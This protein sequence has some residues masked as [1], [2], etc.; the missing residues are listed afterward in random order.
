MNYNNFINKDFRNRTQTVEKQR[1][2]AL[3]WGLMAAGFAVIGVVIASTT[4]NENNNE[5]IAVTETEISQNLNIANTISTEHAPDVQIQ[6]PVHQQYRTLNQKKTP[7]SQD[8]ANNE[9][10]QHISKD[11]SVVETSPDII[12]TD[13]VSA[14]PSITQTD[15]PE[16]QPLKVKSGDSLSVLFDRAKIKPVQLLELMK[17]SNARELKRIHPGDIIK[18]IRNDEGKLLALNYQIDG[19]RY[20]QVERDNDE[21]SAKIL[22]HHIEVRSAYAS[23]EIESSLFLSSAKAGLSQNTTMELAN[24]FGWDID[25]AL[26]IRKGDKFTVIYEQRFKNG[27]KIKD[28]NI[29]AAEFVNQGKVFRALRYNDPVTNYT[30]Y[31]SPD[32]HSLRKAFLRSPVKFSRI[33]SRFTTKRYHPILHRFRSHKGVDYAAGRGTPIRASGDGKVIYKGNKGGYG[34]TVIIKHGSRYTT[35]YAH[36]NSYNRKIRSGKRVKQGQVIGYV[37][38]SGLASGPHLHYEFRVNGVHR[39]P[40]TVKFPSTKPIP[41]RYRDNFGLVTKGYVAQLDVLSRSTLALNDN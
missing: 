15:N 31:Y 34:R 20:L 14:K 25:F 40:L 16:W 13:I 35:L 36:M 1:H 8:I 27:I 33:S 24:V 32:G 5:S 7:A 41:K 18:V 23:G 28:G 17:L 6:L 29:L 4:N 9:A 2:P 21:L 38:S 22:K 39:N 26:D 37:G 19:I 11:Y 12:N 10:S 3:R 30:G